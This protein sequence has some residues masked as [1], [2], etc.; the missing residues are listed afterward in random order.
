MGL[1]QRE[2][3]HRGSPPNQQCGACGWEQ[4]EHDVKVVKVAGE[5][6]HLCSTCRMEHR[7]DRLAD[8]LEQ[9]EET[10]DADV[11]TDLIQNLRGGA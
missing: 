8:H 2:R 9:I 11:N 7:G 5:F 1:R 3:I 10:Q 6:L 4:F